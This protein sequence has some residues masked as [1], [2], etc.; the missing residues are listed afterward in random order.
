MTIHPGSAVLAGLMLAACAASAPS[1]SADAPAGGGP[2][3]YDCSQT[4]PSAT[5]QVIAESAA[6]AE[7]LC[8]SPASGR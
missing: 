4:S 5:R 7:R 6:E 2:G 8:F 1:G 3:L